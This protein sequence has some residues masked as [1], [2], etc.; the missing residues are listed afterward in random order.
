MD[1]KAELLKFADGVRHIR[2]CV[3][4]GTLS[5]EEASE[6]CDK[7]AGFYAELISGRTCSPEAEQPVGVTCPP[8]A[9]LAPETACPAEDEPRCVVEDAPTAVS[10]LMEVGVETL[11][12]HQ[13]ASRCSLEEIT[14]WIEY[15]R[16]SIGLTNPAGLVVSRLR[17]QVP[18]PKAPVNGNCRRKYVSGAYAE[19]IQS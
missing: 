11:T 17:E 14:G 8:E 2:R 5:E 3:E 16:R 15:A 4:Q 6:M 9:E 18:P 10:L 19:Y 12:A 13:L 7:L 1:I